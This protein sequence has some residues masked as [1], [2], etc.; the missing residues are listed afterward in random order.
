[1]NVTPV[2]GSPISR[3]RGGPSEPSAGHGGQVG[4]ADRNVDDTAS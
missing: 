4:Q 1:M 3:F 2:V